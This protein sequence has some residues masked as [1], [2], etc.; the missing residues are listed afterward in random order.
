MAR[1]RAWRRYKNYTKAKRKYDIVHA[2]YDYWYY[3]HFHQFDKGKIHCSCGMCREKT[4][5][6]HRAWGPVL[7]YTI[8]D[9]RRQESM[10]ADL[11][12]FNTIDN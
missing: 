11:E 1:T 10:T 4:R 12:E 8:M 6:R 9:R 2:Q 5:D 3:P 7:V